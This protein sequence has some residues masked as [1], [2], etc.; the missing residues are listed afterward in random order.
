MQE[1]KAKKSDFVGIVT[2][3]MFL[4]LVAGL[5][6]ITPNVFSNFS[7]FFTS[8]EL[9]EIA[10]GYN[11]V[12]PAIPNVVVFQLGF[13]FCVGI[14]VVSSVSVLLHL[15]TSS[16]LHK[17]GSSFIGTLTWFGFSWS[18]YL[19]FVGSLEWVTWMGYTAI[20]LGVSV[21]IG[22]QLIYFEDRYQK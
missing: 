1:T 9:V 14:A 15:L 13:Q 8:F 16:P 12:R 4:I 19:L 18:S 17:T 20:I 5:Y 10:T 21:V 22:S 6:I 11:V 3:G 2:F 7:D